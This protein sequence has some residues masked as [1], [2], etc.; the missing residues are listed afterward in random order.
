MNGASDDVTEIRFANASDGF[1]FDPG[2]WTTHNGGK[3]W[4]QVRSLDGLKRFLVASLTATSN[5]TVY[6]LAEPGSVKSGPT[7][8]PM[9]LLRAAPG[10]TAFSRL[11]AIPFPQS[12]PNLVSAGAS[13]YVD[14]G[15]RGLMSFGPVGEHAVDLPAIGNSAD[16]ECTLASSSETALL[17]I[18]GSSV[19][20]GAMG[21]REAFGTT[22][23][24]KHWTRLPNPGRGA[25][26]ESLGVAETTNGHAVITTF[27]GGGTGLLTTLNHTQSWRTTLSLTN[28]DGATFN[29]LGF[30]NSLDGS[31]IYD[32]ALNGLTGTPR[33]T[34]ILLRTSNGGASWHRVS[35]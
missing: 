31:V 29:D 22:D 33:P 15:T 34:G 1:A 7:G 32:P 28:G 2:L 19:S 20:S 4:V 25:G 23:G 10:S 26:Y 8:G 35:Y 27:S 16:T 9:T 11:Q 5:G 17:A 30:E 3:S 6:A 24:G 14:S 13:V 21:D 18:C 12:K